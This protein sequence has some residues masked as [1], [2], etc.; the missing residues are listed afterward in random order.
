MLTFLISILEERERMSNELMQVSGS[1]IVVQHHVSFENMDPI[2]NDS[3]QIHRNILILLDQLH[4]ELN[5]LILVLISH[6]K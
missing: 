4:K 3:S 5:T 1:S 6:R 2:S